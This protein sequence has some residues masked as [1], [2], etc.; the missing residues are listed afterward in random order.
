MK[1]ITH[2]ILFTGLKYVLR[3]NKTNSPEVTSNSILNYDFEK[4]SKQ[5]ASHPKDQGKHA[6][7]LGSTVSS[8]PCSNTV[9]GRVKKSQTC[10]K[11]AFERNRKLLP[12]GMSVTEPPEN[13]SEVC[14]S[15]R[16]HP[17]TH[18]CVVFGRHLTSLNLKV[19]V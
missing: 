5:K 18:C 9:Q 19:L 4:S 12:F 10:K 8:I 17:L 13:K 15:E 1:W 7:L 6:G 16:T 11:L 2:W 14:E 3:E